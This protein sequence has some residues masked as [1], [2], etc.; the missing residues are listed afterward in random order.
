[1]KLVKRRFYLFCTIILGVLLLSIVHAIVEMWYINLLVSDF[2][3]YGFRL[4]WSQWFLV[5]NVLSVALWIF[6]AWFGYWL[7]IRWWQIVY[8]ERRHWLFRK[9]K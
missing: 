9:R 1:M 2:D 5:H 8:V 4:S 3:M 7:G 6:G